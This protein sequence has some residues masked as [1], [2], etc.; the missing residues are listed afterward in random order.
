MS[1]HSNGLM[2]SDILQKTSTYQRYK[3]GKASFKHLLSDRI[4]HYGQST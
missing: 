3:N 4:L 1:F 2:L